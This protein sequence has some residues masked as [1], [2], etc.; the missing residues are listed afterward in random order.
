MVQEASLSSFLNCHFSYL[1]SRLV[2]D[3][4]DNQWTMV[5]Y[6]LY[7]YSASD[8]LFWYE[9]ISL[10]NWRHASILYNLSFQILSLMV[11]WCF[12]ICIYMFRQEENSM[13]SSVLLYSMHET[14]NPTK[15]RCILS[16]RLNK[17]WLCD[18]IC[19]EIEML[20]I[21]RLKRE[22]LFNFLCSNFVSD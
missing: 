16:R 10:V 5:L 19:A 17:T 9:Q 12:G 3:L 7:I 14:E 20:V 15:S 4:S 2:V 1:K 18:Q 13:F 8:S 22:F 6:R 21:E 11:V